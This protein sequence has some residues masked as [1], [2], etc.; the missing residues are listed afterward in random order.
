M[1]A[2]RTL[3][4]PAAGFGPFDP[5]DEGCITTEGGAYCGSEEQSEDWCGQ[6]SGVRVQSGKDWQV[7]H[8]RESLNELST[9]D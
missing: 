8:F 2:G 7:Q 3:R 9:K 1:M 4:H 5:H 6:M